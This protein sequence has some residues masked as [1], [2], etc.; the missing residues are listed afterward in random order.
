MAQIFLPVQGEGFLHLEGCRLDGIGTEAERGHPP[1]RIAIEAGREG[2]ER[3]DPLDR[4]SA[5]VGLTT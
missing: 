3:I 1:L 4:C 5:A 2:T